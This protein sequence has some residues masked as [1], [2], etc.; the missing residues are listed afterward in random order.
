LIAVRDA[1]K[2]FG[3][4]KAVNGVSLE[5]QRGEALAILG[6]NGSG[7]STLLKL[8][9]GLLAPSTGSVEVGGTTPRVARGRIGYLGHDPWLYP[10][11]SA[12][13][14]LRFFGRLYGLPRVETDR[15]LDRVGMADKRFALAQTLSRG[16]KQRVGLARA[17]LHDPDYLLLDEPTAGLDREMTEAIGPLIR[18]PGR[19]ILVTTHDAVWAGCIA[20]RAVNL[21]AG[22]LV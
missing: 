8:V 6:P 9:A 3:P 13:E 7:K 17:L 1:T 10:H 5:V 16:Q 18:R 19:T 11:L 12:A 2:R 15:M 21:V 14:N 20:A 22:A 4:L